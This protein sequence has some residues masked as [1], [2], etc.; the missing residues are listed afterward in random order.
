MWYSQ[1][2]L[3]KAKEKYYADL[4]AYEGVVRN[5]INSLGNIGAL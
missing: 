5:G 3:K 1:P 2:F 4:A